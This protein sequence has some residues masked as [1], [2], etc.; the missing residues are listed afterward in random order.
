MQISSAGGA[1]RLS[2]DKKILCNFFI[3]FVTDVHESKNT[4]YVWY[5]SRS[6]RENMRGR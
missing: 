5:L 4:S 3:T 1:L 6:F 2:A